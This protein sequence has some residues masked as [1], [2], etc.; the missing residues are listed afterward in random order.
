M[1]WSHTEKPTLP[2]ISLAK[3]TA[4]LSL[5]TTV[6]LAHS[7]A[8]R[9]GC[10]RVTAGVRW[11]RTMW[12]WDWP[13]TATVMCQNRPGQTAVRAARSNTMTYTSSKFFFP[14]QRYVQGRTLGHLE[15]LGQ[16]SQLGN[17][18]KRRQVEISDNL[19]HKLKLKQK[20]KWKNIAFILTFESARNL[21]FWD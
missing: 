14:K 8:G 13:C 20:Q 19:C 16:T 12:H 6:Q 15:E 11:V 7:R 4:C 1:G 2:T 10:D 21:M 3:S 9:L 5:T 18:F 17:I